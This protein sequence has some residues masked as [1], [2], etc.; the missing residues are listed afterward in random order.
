LFIMSERQG[1][2][3]ILKSTTI[4]EGVQRFMGAHRARKRFVVFSGVKPGDLVVDIGCG[5]GHLLPHLPNV[6]YHGF[7]PNPGYVADARRDFGHAGTFHTGLFGED[8]AKQFKDVDLVIISAVLHHLSDD[9]VDDL[10]R[11]L[12]G[13]LKSSGRI[14]SVDPVFHEGQNPVARQLARMDRGKHVRT[15]D[16]Y[17]ALVSRHFQEIEG[18]IITQR[19]PLPYSTLYMRACHRDS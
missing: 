16:Q 8:E 13:I 2:Y 6:D 4:Y 11:L 10:Y 18:K 19:F 9:Q 15:A 7:E 14:A 5:P 1:L 12:S 3:R 17:K